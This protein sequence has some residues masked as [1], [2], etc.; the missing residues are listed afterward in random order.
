MH[1]ARGSSQFMISLLNVCSL[2]SSF[3]PR[4]LVNMIIKRYQ[5]PTKL[6]ALS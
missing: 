6:Q 2:Q 4:R 5:I 3:H 1:V